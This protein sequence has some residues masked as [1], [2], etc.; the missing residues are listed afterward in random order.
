MMLIKLLPMEEGV[1][2]IIMVAVR[3]N[4]KRWV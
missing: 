3:K 4:N 1:G 2:M